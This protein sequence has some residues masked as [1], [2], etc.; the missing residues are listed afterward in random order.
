MEDSRL[1][2]SLLFPSL[3]IYVP[4]HIQPYSKMG[5]TD[6][7]KHEVTCLSHSQAMFC[8]LYLSYGHYHDA[9]NLHPVSY[10]SKESDPRITL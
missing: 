7:Y 2:K 10:S 1:T 5:F 6:L 3:L 9:S 4:T 8:P